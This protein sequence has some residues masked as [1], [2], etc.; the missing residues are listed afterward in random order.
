LS[1]NG[2]REHKSKEKKWAWGQ[3]NERGRIDENVGGKIQVNK[4]LPVFTWRRP[5]L[6][7]CY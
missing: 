1:H 4:K 2:S 5:C 6:P 7:T 3:G